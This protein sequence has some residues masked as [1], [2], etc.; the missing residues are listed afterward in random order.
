MQFSVEIDSSGCYPCSSQQQDEWFDLADNHP[1]VLA[2]TRDRK[3]VDAEWGKHLH[4]F[5][6]ML[7]DR[8]HSPPKEIEQA[9]SN[10]AKDRAIN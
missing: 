5:Q 3:R 4:G 6:I 8:V 7:R 2:H 10:R 9:A 1:D